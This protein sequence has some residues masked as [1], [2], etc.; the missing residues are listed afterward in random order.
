MKRVL[1][2]TFLVG[3]IA[4]A[5]VG[6][7]Q[8]SGLLGAPEGFIGRILFP[9]SPPNDGLGIGNYLLVTALAFG[10]AWS[11]LAIAEV[12]RRCALLLLLIAELIGA[13]W[14]LSIAGVFFQPLP[15]I[16]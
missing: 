1:H 16:L 4:L 13:A 12:S 6:G 15:A 11:V 8:K 3:V 14:L 2:A 5:I 10:V 9:G 7:L